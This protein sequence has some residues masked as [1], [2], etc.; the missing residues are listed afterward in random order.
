MLNL[1]LRWGSSRSGGCGSFLPDAVLLEGAHEGG[2][3]SRRLEAT[4]T[5][6]GRSVNELQVDLF[7]G[8][9]LRVDAQRLKLRFGM[10][11]RQATNTYGLR[12]SVHRLCICP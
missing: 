1:R 5:E 10:I 11:M 3:V 9:P 12:I 7:K 8:S 6:L 4:M 2:L